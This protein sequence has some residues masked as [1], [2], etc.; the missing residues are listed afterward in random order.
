[1]PVILH[2]PITS[3]S[4]EK[5]RCKVSRSSYQCSQSGILDSRVIEGYPRDCYP[6]N[7]CQTSQCLSRQFL[8]EVLNPTRRVHEPV[9]SREV[10]GDNKD[11]HGSRRSTTWKPCGAAGWPLETTAVLVREAVIGCAGMRSLH[12][13]VS[14]GDVLVR[15]CKP[16]F[17]DPCCGQSA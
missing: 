14:T 4:F 8:T 11:D 13:D 15:H 9:S 7:G 6:T 12:L 5:A 10:F 16:S 3:G 17:P 1:M 2:I